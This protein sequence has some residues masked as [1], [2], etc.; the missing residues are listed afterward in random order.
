MNDKY[1]I[2][3]IMGESGCGKDTIASALQL[4]LSDCSQMIVSCTTRPIRDNEVNHRDYHFITS[5]EFAEQLAQGEML[6][7][8]VFNDWCYGTSL[9]YLDKGLLN[10]GVYNPT[11]V[12]I[13]QSIPEVE[14]YVIRLHASNKTRL[15]RQLNR[16]D[17]P[18]VDEIIRR[19]GTD[20]D[21][22]SDLSDVRIDLNVDND[23]ADMSPAD[24]AKT[25]LARSG[26]FVALMDGI[27]QNPYSKPL[28][29]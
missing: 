27:E 6:E 19:Y 5:E 16:E 25:I 17:N 14:T 26:H 22:F 3:C 21:D 23:S 15:L 9:K 29:I 24:V 4:L 2:V 12:N 1:K 7:A 11:G 18:N 10:I 20:K 28:Y 8:T 13:L